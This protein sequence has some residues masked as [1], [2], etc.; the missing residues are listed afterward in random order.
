MARTQGPTTKSPGSPTRE[1]DDLRVLTH[2]RRA[3]EVTL[4]IGVALLLWGGASERAAAFEIGL[5]VAGF[6][7]FFRVWFE[8]FPSARTKLDYLHPKN[9]FLATWRELD[10]EAETERARRVASGDYDT[11]PLIALTSGAVCLALM[12]YFGH[13]VHFRDY[14]DALAPELRDSMW[15]ELMGFAW[16]SVCR[17]AG[18]FVVPLLIAKYVFKETA[19]EHGLETK[20]FFEHAWIYALSYVVVLL[21]VVLVSRHDAH[22]QTYYPFYRQASRSWA[23][24]WMWELLYAAQFFSLE[25]FFRGFWL[26]SMKPSLGSHAIFAMVVPYCMIH[27]GK[28]FL[29]TMAAIFAGVVLGTLAMKTRSIWSGFLIHVSVAI[30]MDMAALMATSG[31]P[32]VMWPTP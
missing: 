7:F 18:Y 29:E 5:A 19:S 22:F 32:E 17:V 27:F 28:P 1:P 20:G 3:S 13:T 26:R 10:A 16:W 23:D 15:F 9:F 31:L 8:A 4:A 14:V 24:F 2:F 6:A 25:F 30:S 12:E 21:C 11:R